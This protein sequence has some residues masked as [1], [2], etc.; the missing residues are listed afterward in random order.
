M[1]TLPDTSGRYAIIAGNGSFPFL[2]LDA[3]RDQGIEPMVVAIKEETLP[4]IAAKVLDMRVNMGPSQAHKI[5]QRALRA[6]EYPV[7]VD[8][9]FGPITTAAVNTVH[10]RHLLVA[11]RSEA[12]GFYRGLVAQRP[13]YAKFE[14]GWLNRAYT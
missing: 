8:G 12:A 4:E 3:A 14:N 13:E 1:G 2:V 11:L 6:A 5:L 10:P 9:V 7:K